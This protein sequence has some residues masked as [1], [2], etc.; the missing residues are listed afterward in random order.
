MRICWRGS[1]TL[2]LNLMG[3]LRLGQ[4]LRVDLHWGFY[5]Y[6]DQAKDVGHPGTELDLGQDDS[7]PQ[8]R[9]MLKVLTAELC[10]QHS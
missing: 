7:S 10:V 4:S 5:P 8:L 3:A 1:L 2:D 6:M 9:H